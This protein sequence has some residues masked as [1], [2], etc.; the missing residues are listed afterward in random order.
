[1]EITKEQKL[2][3]TIVNKAWEDGAYKKELIASPVSAIEGLTGERINLPEGKTIAVRDQTD[4]SVVYI[5]I[6]AKVNMDD[7]E[8]NEEQLEIIAGGGTPTPPK[9]GDT[10]SSLTGLF[11]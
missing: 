5:N 3:Q 10:S 8:L 9:L 7:M 6:P 4:T 11:G 1:M 2:Y